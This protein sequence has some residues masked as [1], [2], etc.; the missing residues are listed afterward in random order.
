[1]F[2]CKNCGHVGAG[3]YCSE[4]GQPY[5]VKRITV[6]SLLHE[7]F[8]FFSHLDKGFPY[9]LKQ[10]AAHPGKMQKNYLLGERSKH[11]KPFSMFFIC[12]T[13]TGLAIYLFT[14]PSSMSGA[15]SFDEM[16]VYFYRHYY[17]LAQAVLIP[18]YAL[19]TWL[20]FQDKNF[21][22]AEALV[23]FV[24]TLAF[25]LLLVILTNAINLL[26]NHMATWYFEIPL[27]AGY[28]TWTNLNFFKRQRTWLVVI[29]SVCGMLIC[30]FTSYFIT[31]LVIHRMMK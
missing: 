28:T 17:V 19:V 5:E 22:Y 20:L 4:C 15:S 21:N 2:I 14:K 26:P 12:A 16:R 31:E 7:V 24:Y 30:W 9:T 3:K 27:L 11:Q 18:Y 10:L 25:L 8:H 1:M 29:K 23:L 13:L 6:S